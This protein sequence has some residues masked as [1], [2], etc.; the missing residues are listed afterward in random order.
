MVGRELVDRFPKRTSKIGEVAFEVE[1][2]TVYDPLDEDSLKI[3]NVSFHVRKGEILGIAGLMGS[4]RTELAMSLFGKSYGH[5]I[6]G[7]IRKDGK[8]LHWA[9]CVRPSN[10]ASRT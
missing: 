9:M 7:T 4:G 10:P 6:T 1:N 8:V 5:N 2:W 3:K